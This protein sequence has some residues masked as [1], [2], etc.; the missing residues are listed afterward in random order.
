MR[1]TRFQLSAAACHDAFIIVLL[2]I[3]LQDELYAGE[4]DDDEVSLSES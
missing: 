1:P 3:G 2:L 4:E